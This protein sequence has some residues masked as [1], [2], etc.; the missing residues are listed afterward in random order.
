MQMETLYVFSRRYTMTGDV[1]DTGAGFVTSGAPKGYVDESAVSRM[2]KKAGFSDVRLNQTGIPTHIRKFFKVDPGDHD[3]AK[4]I[5]LTLSSIGYYRVETA[6]GNLGLL[7]TRYPL[8]DL[9]DTPVSLH[10]MAPELAEEVG[11]DFP[12]LVLLTGEMAQLVRLRGLLER[13]RG[14][15]TDIRNDSGGVL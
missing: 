15:D 8:L 11:P 7:V 2:F 3:G 12:S 14:S 13:Q 5:H 4:E 9:Y 1:S 6:Q 10:D